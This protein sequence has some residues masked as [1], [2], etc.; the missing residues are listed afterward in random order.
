MQ[1]WRKRAAAAATVTHAGL[2]T[3]YFDTKYTTLRRHETNCQILS[4]IKCNNV[5]CEMHITKNEQLY[6]VS[7][8]A[9][10]YI[11]IMNRKHIMRRS[12]WSLDDISHSITSMFQ[13][14]KFLRFK[15]F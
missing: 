7:D 13:A 15:L 10:S 14:H 8:L 2:A 3:I 12:K 9:K 11:E 4:M 6:I 1:W 5:A